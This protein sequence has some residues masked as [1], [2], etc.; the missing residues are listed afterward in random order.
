MLRDGEREV[1]ADAVLKAL[2][3]QERLDI[4]VKAVA[5]QEHL[6]NGRRTHPDTTRDIS[7]S[8]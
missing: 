3:R 7:W 8:S 4:E 6:E 2:H 5:N 1:E